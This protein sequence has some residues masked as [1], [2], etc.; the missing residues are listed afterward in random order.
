MRLSRLCGT[1]AH[2]GSLAAN[3]PRL[4]PGGRPRA[5]PGP[6]LSRSKEPVRASS[7]NL[8]RESDYVEASAV[9]AGGYTSE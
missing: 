8:T 6:R 3:M 9:F 5:S 7:R 4:G 1:R 2:T